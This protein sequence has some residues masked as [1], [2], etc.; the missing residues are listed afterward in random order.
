MAGTSS[1][2][3]LAFAAALGGTAAALAG[4]GA[5]GAF[6][7]TTT[8]TR[9]PRPAPGPLLQPAS[10]TRSDAHPA[11]S[12][13]PMRLYAARSRGV[14]TLEAAFDPH[15][16]VTASGS[17][18]VVDAARGLILTNSHVVTNSAEATSPGEVRK[19]DHVYVS[20][21]GGERADARIVG[22]DLFDDVAVVR[23]DASRLRLVQV[24]LGSSSSVRV[25]APVAAIGSPF[26]EPGSLSVGVVSQVGRQ[27][28]APAGVCFL[29][30]GAIQTDAAINH[31]NSGG[32]LFDA[33]GRVIGINAQIDSS[34]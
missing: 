7:H 34:T 27:I 8:I 30:S 12:L 1:A 2:V 4:A 9:P 19:A 29:T 5:L 20:L 16:G 24:P 23:L 22:Y 18:F 21:A 32:P 26:E 3:A 11:T 28:P 13:D 33:A 17:G 14:V 25:G 31:G 15:P 6:D 10:L